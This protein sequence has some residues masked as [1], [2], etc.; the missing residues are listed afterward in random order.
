MNRLI[1]FLLLLL[2]YYNSFSQKVD[3]LLLKISHTNSPKEKWELWGEISY[4]YQ[5][6]KNDSGLQSATAQMLQTALESKNDTLIFN[7]YFILGSYYEDKADFNHSLENHFKALRIAEKAKL[8]EGICLANEQAAVVYKQ[9]NN[10][11]QALFH[12]RKAEELLGDSSIK[13]S[14]PWLYR[15]VYANTAQVYIQINKIDSALIYAQRGFDVVDKKQDVFGYAQLLDIIAN[16]Y[17]KQKRNDLADFSFKAGIAFSD[18][19]NEDISLVTTLFDYSIFLL[20]TGRSK[21]AKRFGLKSLAE[22]N[23]RLKGIGTLSIKIAD[24]LSEVY[25]STKQFDSAYYYSSSRDRQKDTVFNQ[26]KLAAISNLT[27]SEKIKVTEEKMERQENEIKQKQIQ[28][29]FLLCALFLVGIIAYLSYRSFVNK[30]RDALLI[31]IEKKRSDDLLL[32]ILPTEV[33]EELKLK[34]SAAAKDFESVTVLF[35][36]FK[37]FTNMSEKLS[38][39]ELVNEINYCYSAFDNIIT[40]HGIEKIKTIGDSYMCAGGLPVANKTNAI[41]AVTAAIE[42]HDFM[43]NEKQKKEKEGKPFFE[44]RIGCN[45][46]SVVAGIVGIK[47]FAYD[48]WGDTV[49]IASRM[50]SSGEAGKINISGSTYELVKEK[51]NCVYRGKI[52]AKNKGMIDMY[53]VN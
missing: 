1:L 36:D 6:Q 37:N 21:E 3:S 25:S 4:E 10:N 29:Y 50:E 9:L 44:I 15:A 8:Y 7:T 12:L 34:G 26:Q 38:A 53:F 40:R 24:V 49:N 51:F 47:K 32:N 27:F 17:T 46:G 16:I 41:D 18:S 14:I 28:L 23:K 43:L 20:N 52:E 13:N 42:I 35:T 5:R 33:A 22:H 31:Q 39:Q 48:I 45:T 19:V 11:E 30:K 2:S